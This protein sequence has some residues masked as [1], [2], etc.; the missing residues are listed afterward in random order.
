MRRQVLGL[1]S[2]LG[3]LAI[4]CGSSKGPDTGGVMV[5]ISTD[6]KIDVARLTVTVG[7]TAL[8][9]GLLLS[10]DYRIP[11]EHRLP[12][13][14][15][16]V[17]NGDPTATATVTL[18]AYDSSG[19]PVDRRDAIVTQIPVDRVVAWP[20]VLSV[21]CAGQVRADGTSKCAPGTCDPS[22][23][24][25]TSSTVIASGLGTYVPG[26]ERDVG[27]PEILP[28]TGMVDGQPETDGT[29]AS[30][31]STGDT[32]M[33][34][35]TDAD[36]AGDGGAVCGNGVVESGE[37]CDLGITSGPGKCPTACTSSDVCS[38][39]QLS[40]SAC[41]L[42][43]VSKPKVASG[44]TA[45]GC[46]PTGANKATDTDCPAACGNGVTEPGETCDD[47][48]AITEV[49][50]YGL[51]SCTV[52]NSSCQSSAGA[53]SYCGDSLTDGT[54]GEVCD[55][56][57]SNG[58]TSCSYGVMSCAVCAGDCKSNPAGTTIYCGDGVKNGAEG[59]DLGTDN[60]KTAC[61]Y[62][63]TSCDV[64]SASCVLSA[65][66]ASY[67]GD[68]KIDAADGETCDDGN[69]AAGEGCSAA[70][71][72]EAGY[73]C[74]GTPSSCTKPT[75]CAGGRQ[76][77]N[78]VPIT[79]ATGA[80]FWVTTGD[81][82]KDS[83]LDVVLASNTS[84]AVT[85]LLGNGDG[86]FGA[87]STLSTGANCAPSL[88]DVDRDGLVDIVVACAGPSPSIGVLRNLGG[89]TF[90][91]LVTL[92][93]H[94][95]GGTLGLAVG[96]VDNDGTIDAVTGTSAWTTTN[97]GEILFGLG[98]GGTS[99]THTLYSFGYAKMWSAVVADL[100]HTG[101][102]DVVF[103]RF[104]GSG[105]LTVVLSSAS[106]L[107]APASYDFSGYPI[108]VRAGDVNADGWNDLVAGNWAT[109]QVAV[110]TNQKNGTFSAPALTGLAF[111][112]C[113][114]SSG[115]LWDL[116]LPDLDGDGRADVA[117]PGI[118]DNRLSVLLSSGGTFAS[119]TETYTVG[120]AGNQPQGA[121]SGDVNRD[122]KPDVIVTS[123]NGPVQLFLHCP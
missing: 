111:T 99:T 46:C 20:I 100:D 96:D 25:C 21:N 91:A 24:G 34:T 89:G 36:A 49:C 72:V 123:T 3:S 87:P 41:T 14:V 88:A 77:R 105:G 43:C 4:G 65:G 121:T 92:A 19:V 26:G 109:G 16:I 81:V 75:E 51:T 63:P 93:T 94:V 83:K 8:D 78:P 27:V 119:V 30:E 122:G 1:A 74:A 97:N 110:L 61:T 67:C 116:A 6:G 71:V 117:V 114:G 15:A 86:T 108:V 40:G 52:C 112:N 59:C 13:T 48:N 115:C 37:T 84:S 31:D 22:T 69:S 103:D 106:G 32:V 85:L 60:G 118:N 53:T 7:T 104:Y 18:V 66:T 120:A 47:S 113:N 80:G 68:G 95:P 107:S 101:G 64:C 82:N 17:S 90:G 73:S 62:G 38:T 10:G 57:A 11:S 50:A 35:P 12:S 102:L 76:L 23:G 2:V 33:D 54:H 55:D 79:A 9:S 5:E 70:C 44:T 58:A 42:T 98:I 29:D 28:D 56:G 45:D 39:A